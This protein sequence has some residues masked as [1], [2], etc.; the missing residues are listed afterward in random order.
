MNALDGRRRQYYRGMSII[1]LQILCCL[2]C[3]LSATTLLSQSDLRPEEV[4]SGAMDRR[5]LDAPYSAKLHF[6]SDRKQSD[7]SVTRIET[8][9]M[10]AR[11]SQGRMYSASERQWSYFDGM[12]NVT[13]SEMLYRID[14]PVT[15]TDTRWNTMSKVVKVIH[16]GKPETAGQVPMTTQPAFSENPISAP[17]DTVEKLGERTIQGFAAEGIRS[18]YTT[19]NSSGSSIV[20]VHESWYSPKLKA[21]LLETNDDPRSGTTRSELIDVVQGEPDPSRYQYPADYIVSQVQMP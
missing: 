3:C 18:S 1:R 11:D 21:D 2:A 5:V 13:G 15:A 6:T 8:N 4:T 14:D 12:K 17:G 20:V 10:K 9:G 16:W 19:Q 7:G